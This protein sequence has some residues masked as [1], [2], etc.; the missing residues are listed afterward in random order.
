MHILTADDVYKLKR[1]HTYTASWDH[2]DFIVRSMF[3]LF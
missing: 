2:L 3:D 1:L